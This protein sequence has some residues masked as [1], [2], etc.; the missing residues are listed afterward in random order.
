MGSEGRRVLEVTPGELT[1]DVFD[2]PQ[3]RRTEDAIA[4]REGGCVE[5][6]R[7]KVALKSGMG[8]SSAGRGRTV[9]TAD[10]KRSSKKGR[11]RED[12]HRVAEQ[13]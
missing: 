10:L 8:R 6:A 3:K 5:I 9:K 7:E 11:R 4:D 2:P 13:R 12:R 1:E